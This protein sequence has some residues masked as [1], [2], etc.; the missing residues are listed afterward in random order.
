MTFLVVN[1]TNVRFLWKFSLPSSSVAASLHFIHTA[2]TVTH[3]IQITLTLVILW[4]FLKEVQVMTFGMVLDG[5]VL[6][7]FIQHRRQVKTQLVELSLWNVIQDALYTPFYLIREESPYVVISEIS[8]ATIGM[9][10]VFSKDGYT[11][12]PRSEENIPVCK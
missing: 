4:I 10:F 3:G 6:W 9:L 11:G 7:L 12:S 1:L 2:R 8:F 5:T